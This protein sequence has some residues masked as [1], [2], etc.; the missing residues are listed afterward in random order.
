MLPGQRFTQQ[1][2]RFTVAGQHIAQM[3]DTTR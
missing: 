3:I 2:Q 1:E